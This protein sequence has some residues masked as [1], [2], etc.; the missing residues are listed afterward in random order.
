MSTH[1]HPSSHTKDHTARTT[2]NPHRCH[3]H[4]VTPKI[5][6]LVQLSTHT[7]V[8]PIKSHQRS[9]CSYN[10][11]PTQMSHPSSHT[12]DHTAR[13]TVNPH[14]C[15][16]HQVTPKI[17]LLVQ[18][19][20][21]TDVTPIKS[22]Q[23]SHCSYNCQPTQMSH[24]SSHTKDH[25]A[26]TT[27]N[28]HRCHT[29][30]VTPKITLLLQLCQPT[31]MSNPSSHTKDHTARTT[32]NPHRCHTH[33]VTPKIT[34]LVQLSTHTDVTPI[35]SHQRSH[36]SYN[37]QPTQMSH[38]SSHTKDHTARTT[39]TDVTPIKSH[40]RSHCSYNC[41]PTQMS[42]P[43]S[44][45]KDHTARTTHT[46]VT[47][48]KS[49]QRSHCSYN[50]HTPIK[51]HQRS[52]CSYNPHRCHTHQVTPKITL[53]VQP[54][55]MSH[56]SSH[57][58]DHT[59]RTT[60]TDV[61]P[62]KSHQRS[63]CSYNPHRCHTHQVTPKITLLVQP[64]QMSHPSSHTKD[65]TARTT[66]TDVT[67]I[68]SHQRSH[69]SYNPHR[70]HTHQVTPKITLLVQPTQMSHPSSH[71][72]DHTARTT[73]TDVTPIKSHQRS[74]CS[75]NPHTPIKS[76]Q[77]SHCSYNPHRCHTHQVTPKI[78][79]L[80]QPT[81]MSHPSSHTKDHTARTTHTHPSSHTKEHVA[82]TTT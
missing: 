70:C 3:T 52:H 7:D 38:P 6:L 73:H 32:V 64:T 66:H 79:L 56:P 53:L 74:H 82:V 60:H 37:C 59:A 40:Q 76:H 45:T 49:H 18:L 50:P 14:R 61:T 48:I 71:T 67:P 58:K 11:Q 12:K 55:Q 23:R 51:S 78:T 44:H 41:Q 8:T 46:D 30:Q 25:T 21:H 24:P 42:H 17:T 43:S 5:T 54:T 2:V 33:Q 36:C 75:Y 39:H 26:R 28:P 77:R 27:V 16:T 65:H 1:T 63:H 22:H 4:Q 29:H 19:S 69:C 62:I 35:K 10:C 47:P 20:T 15:H 72:K 9:H 31:Q 57:T 34:L 68:K 13:T 81:Q 80:V